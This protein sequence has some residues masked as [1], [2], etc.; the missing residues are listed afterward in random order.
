MDLTTVQIFRIVAVLLGISLKKN[1]WTTQSPGRIN[2]RSVFKV[3]LLLAGGFNP[4]EQYWSNWIISPCRARNKEYL[5]PAW[6][7]IY[8][9]SNSRWK[10][11]QN[12]LH[13]MNK[14]LITVRTP[15]G[16]HQKHQKQPAKEEGLKGWKGLKPLLLRSI[17]QGEVIFN[18]HERIKNDKCA[19]L[20]WL[21]S[22]IES[23]AIR[24]M[25]EFSF[26]P[27]HAGVRTGDSNRDACWYSVNLQFSVYKIQHIQF[28]PK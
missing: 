12:G 16:C 15:W 3:P 24:R 14:H 8:H 26:G 9:I 10:L 25:L 13:S 2:P 6:N 20:Q 27:I 23:S 19:A 17:R 5:K 21:S 4:S 18:S 22:E 7:Y 1:W 11:N 28:W